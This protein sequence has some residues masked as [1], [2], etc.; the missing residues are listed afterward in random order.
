M[1]SNGI[2]A[3]SDDYSLATNLIAPPSAD[4]FATDGVD[5]FVEFIDPQQAAE[6]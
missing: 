5:G 4:Y 1:Y 2:G 3:V 6:P